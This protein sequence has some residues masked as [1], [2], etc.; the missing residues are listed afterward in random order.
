LVEV[1]FAHRMML[2]SYAKANLLRSYGSIRVFLLLSESRFADAFS[3][4]IEDLEDVKSEYSEISDEE[5]F[6]L[7]NLNLIR[8]VKSYTLEGKFWVLQKE[9]QIYLITG[10]PSLYVDRCISYLIEEMYPRVL[11]GYLTSAEIHE[12]LRGL[13]ETSKENLYTIRYVTKRLYERKENPETNVKYKSETFE[14]AFEKARKDDVWVDSIRVVSKKLDFK[15]DRSSL[16]QFYKGAFEDYLPLLQKWSEKCLVKHKMFDKRSRQDDPERGVSPLI[17]QFDFNLFDDIKTRKDLIEKIEDYSFCSYS[18]VHDGNPYTYLTVLDGFDNSSFSVRT[19]N[20][21]SLLIVPQ[22]RATKASLMRFS[23]YIVEHF[24][25]G[26]VRDF[27][28]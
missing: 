16:L 5:G 12:L 1:P 23:Q 22:I 15:I 27:L 2:N 18:I 21:D 20:S 17:I 8:K 11:I 25:D 7:W 10:E 3:E 28:Q 26:Q 4:T 19:F 14:T 9:N 13:K 24:C 6:V